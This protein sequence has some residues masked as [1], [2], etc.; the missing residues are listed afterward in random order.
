M[1]AINSRPPHRRE[2]VEIDTTDGQ[3]PRAML[4]PLL[5]GGEPVES[6]LRKAQYF[7]S[8]TPTSDHREV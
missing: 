2:S 3:T 7:T 4:A 1:T 6:L 8:G 5:P